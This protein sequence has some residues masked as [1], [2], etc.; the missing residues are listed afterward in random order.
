MPRCLPRHIKT[1]SLRT[2]LLQKYKYHT[3]FRLNRNILAIQIRRGIFITCAYHGVVIMMYRYMNMKL[4]GIYVRIWKIQNNVQFR[5]TSLG[6]DEYGIQ[7]YSCVE[8]HR[9]YKSWDG[10]GILMK[11][12]IS[13]YRR[14]D[15]DFFE[16]QYESVFI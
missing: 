9:L 15:L 3:Y 2:P 7:W 4:S 1:I 16:D 6:C 12:N 5:R 14:Y 13:F 11:N 10:V 8:N